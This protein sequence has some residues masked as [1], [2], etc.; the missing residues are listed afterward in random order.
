V[1]MIS[2]T[3]Q[4]PFKA[5]KADHVGLRVPD[6]DAALQWYTERLDFRFVASFPI[7]DLTYA[8]ISPADSDWRI[9]CSQ[10]LGLRN[11]PLTQDWPIAVHCLVSITLP[12]V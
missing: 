3:S 11:A 6:Y 7:G 5:W 8:F 2:T 12:F 1:A 4:S 9:D 10:D